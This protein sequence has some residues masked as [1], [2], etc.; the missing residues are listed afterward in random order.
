[1]QN[2]ENTLF[3][4]TK[5]RFIIRHPSTLPWARVSSAAPAFGIQGSFPNPLIV[6]PRLRVA[7]ASG[8][9]TPT[10]PP[11]AP[12]PSR[13]KSSVQTSCKMTPAN[14][15]RPLCGAAPRAAL[16]AADLPNLGA[17]AR[18]SSYTR[19]SGPSPGGQRLPGCRDRSLSG[20]SCSPEWPHR[21]SDSKSKLGD[22]KAL[23]TTGFDLSESVFDMPDK[24][25][26]GKCMTFKNK[27]A[28]S[29]G[30]REARR[31][32]PRRADGNWGRAHP[33]SRRA[34]DSSLPTS[35]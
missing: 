10:A 30:P 20:D 27:S 16:R 11:P 1:M 8:V 34:A 22:K 5:E 12:T 21:D 35:G 19:A 17:S 29:N 24:R 28:G 32:A 26:R 18:G 15:S 14:A 4:E 23:K 13:E 9:S 31:A 33:V 7:E 2:C 25:Q 6:P 3:G